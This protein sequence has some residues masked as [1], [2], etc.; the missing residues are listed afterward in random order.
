MFGCVPK[1]TGTQWKL[2]VLAFLEL[3]LQ[4][5]ESQLT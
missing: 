1:N 4:V 3:K 2:E 5:V